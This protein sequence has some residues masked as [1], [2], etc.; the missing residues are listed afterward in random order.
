MYKRPSRS[1]AWRPRA[2]SCCASCSRGF[3][4]GDRACRRR[5]QSSVRV[6]IAL[7]ERDTEVREHSLAVR[8]NTFVRLEVADGIA[9]IVADSAAPD[10]LKRVRILHFEPPRERAA[11]DALWRTHLALG[12]DTPI[13]RPVTTV[14]IASRI[15]AVGPVRPSTFRGTA[16]FIEPHCAWNECPAGVAIP[17][18]TLW[19]A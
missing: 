7:K 8:N 11:H 1:I 4:R 12:K 10:R 6:V 14:T 18:R 16:P 2:R 19:H 3:D 17:V 13:T 5:R 9:R 15:T